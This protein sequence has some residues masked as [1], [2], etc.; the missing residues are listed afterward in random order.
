MSGCQETLASAAL[1]ADSEAN[2]VNYAL[3]SGEL[4][5]GDYPSFFLYNLEQN[6][7]EA[8]LNTKELL[9]SHLQSA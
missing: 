7:M 4:T 1:G 9:Y 5:L 2:Q 6:K 8:F 3:S